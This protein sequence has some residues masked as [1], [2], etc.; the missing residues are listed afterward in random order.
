M[1]SPPTV[2]IAQLV[3]IFEYFNSFAISIEL[4]RELCDDAFHESLSLDWIIPQRPR[5]EFIKEWFSGAVRSG[6]LR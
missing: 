3:R 6:I 5:D 4:F 1:P 2:A